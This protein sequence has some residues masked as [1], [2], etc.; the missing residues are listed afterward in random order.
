[1]TIFKQELKSQKISLIIWSLSIG[2]LI[3]ACVLMYPEMKSEM[4]DVSKMFAS[5][6]S[7]TAAFGMDK[8]NFGTLLGFYAVEAGNILGIGG[9]FFAAITAVSALMKEE[10]DRT[11]EF[12]LTHPISRT[13]VVA[14][15]LLSTFA[16]ILILNLAVL[17]CSILSILMIGE[18]VDWSVLL[19]FHLAALLMQLEIGGICFCI[20]AFLTR[21]G[22]GI[23]IGI[24]AAMYSLNIVANIANGANFLKYFTPF[25]Y[26]EGA[27]IINDRALNLGYII[28]GIVIMLACTVIAFLKY[29]KK[30]IS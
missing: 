24:A 9:A 30:D 6:G 1:M 26:T 28:P 17:L 4:D 5:M 7:F 11:A 13:K 18:D 23:G 20:S 29:N 19:L 27:D 2:L 25:G 21:S 12:L 14:E 8:L 10:K 15:K 3:A 22:I 16:I